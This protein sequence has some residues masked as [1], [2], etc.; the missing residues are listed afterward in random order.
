LGNAI[1]LSDS[2][3]EVAAKVKKMYTDPDH[4][5]IKTITCNSYQHQN[6]Q[7]RYDRHEVGQNI[8]T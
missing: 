2:A 5:R 3:D 1:Y 8:F 6:K 4:L 7:Y